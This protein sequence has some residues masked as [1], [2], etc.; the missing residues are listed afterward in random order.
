MQYDVR[1]QDRIFAAAPCI[2]ISK[3]L[4]LKIVIFCKLFLQLG[5]LIAW[6]ISQDFNEKIV[7]VNI[8]LKNDGLHDT[9]ANATIETFVDVANILVLAKVLVPE[10]N[11]EERYTREYF[12]SSVDVGRVVKAIKGNTFIRMIAESLASSF[13]F[14]LK[15]PMKRVRMLQIKTLHL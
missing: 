2:R 1:R 11:D 13:D 9:I 7:I 10:S 14:E 3:E 12:R 15:F 4:Q 5:A 6:K 8:T